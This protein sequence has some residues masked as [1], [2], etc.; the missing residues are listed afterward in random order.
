MS[1]IDAL[2]KQ[3]AEIRSRFRDLLSRHEYPLEPKT[4]LLAAYVDI[5]L[6]HHEAISLLIKTKVFGS[7]FAL[8]R[9]LVET[10]LRA[11]WIN[12]IAKENQID[13]ARDKS[14]FPPMSQMVA[15]IDQTYDT[16]SFFQTFKGSSW[17]AM[18]SYAHSGAHQIGRRFTN[19]EVKASYRDG[20]IVEVL[21]V[22]NTVV[23]LLAVAF[24][25][26]WDANVKLTK[27]KRFNA[28]TNESL[29]TFFGRDAEALP[30]KGAI[31][32]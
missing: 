19:S 6:E 24:L 22:T 21:N 30:R 14:E 5:A 27:Y 3:G 25:K 11:L 2:R 7:A 29:S 9:P 8:V 1:E 28:V 10:M 17:S 12:G 18:C 15:E 20:E 31:A 4:S 13:K 23:I 26:A 16:G 32:S